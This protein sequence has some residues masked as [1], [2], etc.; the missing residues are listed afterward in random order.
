MEFFWSVFSCI[1]TE[2]GGSISQ[3]SVR[4]Q[5]NKDQKKLCIWT[6][7]TQCFFVQHCWTK[8][9]QT[10]SSFN[11]ISRHQNSNGTRL[12]STIS[13][14]QKILRTS[15]KCLELMATTQPAMQKTNFGSSSR[16]FGKTSG[17]MLLK[18]L[19]VHSFSI[20]LCLKLSEAKH[21]IIFNST[22]TT[23]NLHFVH[24]HI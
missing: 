14:N 5:K 7:F 15:L 13:F 10:F 23:W 16:N 3:Y 20:I 1:Q 24:F 21:F 22:Q 9:L 6:L 18:K 11:P 4:M 2:Y 17:K 12:L 8:H 19:I